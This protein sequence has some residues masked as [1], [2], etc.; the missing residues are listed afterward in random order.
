MIASERQQGPGRLLQRFAGA[1][2]PW[3]LGGVQFSASSLLGISECRGSGAQVGSKY[4]SFVSNTPE[5]ARPA[6]LPSH[7]DHTVSKDGDRIPTGSGSNSGCASIRRRNSH[8]Q[9]SSDHANTPL[10]E[11]SNGSDFAIGCA[12][13][14]R[15]SSPLRRLPCAFGYFPI[16]LQWEDVRWHST[17][18]K[19][20]M[21]ASRPCAEQIS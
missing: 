5:L 16:S 11:S 10:R 4:G 9:G 6:T 20:R 3:I 14:N 7:K 1:E 12:N 17:P 13:S 19:R 18:S 15:C 8:G 2:L 21:R